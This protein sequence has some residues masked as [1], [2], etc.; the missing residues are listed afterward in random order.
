MIEYD[1]HPPKPDDKYPGWTKH[2]P[3]WRKTYTESPWIKSYA[4]VTKL[5]DGTR[6]WFSDYYVNSITD[7]TISTAEYLMR[8]LENK[9]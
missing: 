3:H 9:L 2:G 5:T 6:V 8:T 1:D 7:E 4:I